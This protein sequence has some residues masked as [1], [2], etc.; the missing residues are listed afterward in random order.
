M[1]F[2]NLHK[3]TIHRFDN[4]YITYDVEGLFPADMETKLFP[5][6]IQT[7][8]ISMYFSHWLSHFIGAHLNVLVMVLELC[9]Y[10]LTKVHSSNYLTFSQKLITT[11]EYFVTLKAHCC[12]GRHFDFQSSPSL[13]NHERLQSRAF[14]RG[15]VFLLIRF[16]TDLNFSS[17]MVPYKQPHGERAFSQLVQ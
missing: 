1:I 3:P 12:I 10:I 11:N 8:S 16:C 6:W 9:L 14:V 2:L 13:S 5:P 4:I 17:D 15:E 7:M